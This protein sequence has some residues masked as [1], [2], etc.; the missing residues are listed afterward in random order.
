M[1]NSPTRLSNSGADTSGEER[2]YRHLVIRGKSH[3]TTPLT[4]E[5][6]LALPTHGM[7]WI[8][9]Q[10]TKKRLHLMPESPSAASLTD[11]NG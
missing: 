4:A 11:P 8:L 9:W 1:Q 6:A 7:G 5:A 3:P 2:E 10:S